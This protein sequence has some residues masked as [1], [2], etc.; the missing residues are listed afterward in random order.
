MQ[1]LIA[2]HFS[3]F[4]SNNLNRYYHNINIIFQKFINTTSILYIN[5]SFDKS[6]TLNYKTTLDAFIGNLFKTS[7]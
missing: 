2:N 3:F 7:V 1:Q 4:L 6:L 5:L